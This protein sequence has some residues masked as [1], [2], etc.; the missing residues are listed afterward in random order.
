[1]SDFLF[2]KKTGFEKFGKRVSANS[3]TPLKSPKT[4]KTMTY[5]QNSV[6]S[7]QTN[8]QKVKMFGSSW[9]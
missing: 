4:C 6:F 3:A 1:M 8:F 9:H 2:K 5:T 7:R